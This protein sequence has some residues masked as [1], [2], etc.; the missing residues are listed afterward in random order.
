MGLNSNI[1][2]TKIQRTSLHDGP[3]IRTTAF[4]KGCSLRCPWCCNPENIEP[5][6][7]PYVKDGMK[8]TYGKNYT[9]DELVTELL[10]DK[11]FYSGDITDPRDFCITS[12]DDIDHLPGGV[13]FSGGEALL[14]MQ[15]LI[16]VCERLKVEGVHIAIETSLFASPESVTLAVKLIDFFYIDVKILDGVRCKDILHGDTNVYKDNLTTVFN[17][18]KPV[19][20]RIPV[21][22]GYTDDQK[23]RR[24][25]AELIRGLKNSSHNVL[26]IELLKEHN[27]GLSKYE[28]LRAAGVDIDLPANHGVSDEFMRRYKVELEGVTDLPIEVMRV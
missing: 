1:L 27:L 10:K 13:T 17:S 26:K 15:Q 24:A 18:G 9:T 21:I 16:P 14:Q 12:A 28:S 3:G 22:G 25:V 23:N 5:N 7:Q 2:I 6:P 4:L 20:L 11:P 8:G 19:I